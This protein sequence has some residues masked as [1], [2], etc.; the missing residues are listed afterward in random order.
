MQTLSRDMF[1]LA[2][3]LD[4]FRLLS[5]YFGGIGFYISNSRALGGSVVVSGCCCVL[6]EGAEVVVVVVV[7]C[8]LCL[9]LGLMQIK[10]K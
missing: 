10:H 2:R 4:F 8:S 1:R 9:S 5:F 3:R 7:V 6:R